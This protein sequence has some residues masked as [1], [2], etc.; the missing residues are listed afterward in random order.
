MLVSVIVARRALTALDPERNWDEQLP[1]AGSGI[2]LSNDAPFL[3][4]I[5]GKLMS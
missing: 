5:S 4:I 3:S 1:M 2:T